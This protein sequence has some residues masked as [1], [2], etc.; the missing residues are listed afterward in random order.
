MC[1]E[2]RIGSHYNPS[3]SYGGYCLPKDTK[4][5]LA[6]Y[7]DVPQG[8]IEAIVDA[9]CTRKDFAPDQVLSRMVGLLYPPGAGRGHR[10]EY[11]DVPAIAFQRESLNRFT[12]FEAAS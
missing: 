10:N 8:L 4:Q 9:N 5:L 3:F 12:H 6:N 11:F 1:L 7:K 2:P